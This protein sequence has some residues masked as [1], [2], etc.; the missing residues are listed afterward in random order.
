M[1]FSTDSPSSRIVFG[2]NALGETKNQ[3]S[4]LC[5]HRNQSRPSK[6]SEKLGKLSNHKRIILKATSTEKNMLLNDM[7]F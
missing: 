6:T 1:G 3:H 5:V 4:L 2:Y 7:K